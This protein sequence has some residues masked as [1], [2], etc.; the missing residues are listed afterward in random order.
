MHGTLHTGACVCPMAESTCRS[1][2]RLRLCDGTPSNSAGL[3]GGCIHTPYC[4][5][6]PDLG[7]AFRARPV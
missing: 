4:V 7:L 3:A 2:P 1:E 6:V 5:W